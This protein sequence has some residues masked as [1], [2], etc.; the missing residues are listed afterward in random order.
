NNVVVTNTDPV[1]TRDADRGQAVSASGTFNLLAN[2]SG[3]GVNVYTVPANKRF[4]L[5][6][7]SVLS[8]FGEAGDGSRAEIEWGGSN[9]GNGHFQRQFLVPTRISD[10]EMVSSA[11][12][13]MTFEPLDVIQCRV[14]RSTV[15]ASI[16]AE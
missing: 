12:V 9:G 3:S 16:F 11:A 5:Q 6:Y 4:V 13:P 1:P 2:F 15:N 8:R 10:T 14:E 7:V